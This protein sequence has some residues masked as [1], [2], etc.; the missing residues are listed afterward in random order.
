MG[1][2]TYT[3]A[4]VNEAFNT[5]TKVEEIA[6]LPVAST[7]PEQSSE[8]SASSDDAD[9]SSKKDSSQS[10]LAKTADANGLVV[11]VALTI[12]AGAAFCLCFA[13]RLRRDF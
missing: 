8:S 5:Q 9:T 1:E 4:F 2:G 10:E 3:A 12:A 7:K 13:V 11:P 6:K